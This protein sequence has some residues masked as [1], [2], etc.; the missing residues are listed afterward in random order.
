[1][2]IKVH[3]ADVV[4]AENVRRRR[5]DP[6]GGPSGRLRCHHP[7]LELCI[8]APVT[9][10]LALYGLHRRAKIASCRS[11]P[12][13]CDARREVLDT[14]ETLQLREEAHVDLAWTGRLQR[15]RLE[16]A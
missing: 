6:V 2:S 5:R 7:A 12:R 15:P 4:C 16:P 9:E 3:G 11:A 10:S 14:Q 8:G 13:R 1:M